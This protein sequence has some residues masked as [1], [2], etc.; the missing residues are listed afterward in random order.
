MKRSSLAS[1][2]SRLFSDERQEP[3]YVS[4]FIGRLDDFGQNGM[5]VVGKH[6]QDVSSRGS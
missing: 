1:G 6:S 3:V 5:D 4:P 2:R